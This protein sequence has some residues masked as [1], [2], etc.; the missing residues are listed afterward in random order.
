MPQSVET[1]LNTRLLSSLSDH[2][3]YSLFADA[4]GDDTA[5]KLGLREIPPK[6]VRLKPIAK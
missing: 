6:E 2:T 1:P 4:F 3:P 5:R